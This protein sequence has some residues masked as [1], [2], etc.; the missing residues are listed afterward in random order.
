MGSRQ[1][2]EQADLDHTH[3]LAARAQIFGGIAGGFGAGPHQHD[4][5]FGVRVAEVVERV[6]ATAGQVG[7]LVHGGLNDVRHLGVERID[8]LAALEIDVGVLRRAA[9]ERP[10]RIQRSGAMRQHQ[11]V[12]DH[13][14]DFAIGQ[15]SELVDLMRGAEAVEEMDEGH[16]RLQRGRLGDQRHVVRFLHRTGRQQAEAGG[17]DRHHV[18]MVAEDRQALG[19][20]RAGGDVEH[21]RGQLAGDLVHV[22][23]HQ[24]EPLRRGEGGGQRPGLQRA[25]RRAGRAALALHFH[26]HGHAA[27][28]VLDAF[29]GP[30]VGQF[31]HGRGWGNGID[32]AN[33]VDPIG[34]V[35]GGLVAFDGSDLPFGHYCS[36]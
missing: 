34:D 12:V 19:R 10:I 16:P 6:V 23:D 25:V 13:R 8:R 11:I 2:Q 5:P 26:H 15:Q 35:G 22:G 31:S 20:Q 7:E 24:H 33:F 1:R 4:D 9:D 32:G 3:P 17:A 30:L 36:L 18:L 28:D 14:P 27:P 21:R 29:R